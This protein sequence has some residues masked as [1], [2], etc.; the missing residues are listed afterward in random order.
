[1]GRT[2]GT[3][4]QHLEKFFKRLKSFKEELRS[5]NRKH[6]NDLEEKAYSNA[7]AASRLNHSSPGMP[8]FLSM[9]LGL[10]KQ[11]NEIEGRIEKLEAES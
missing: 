2:N 9:I 6:F 7:H 1:M 11:I 8:A 4:R 5:G 3:Y 10:Q